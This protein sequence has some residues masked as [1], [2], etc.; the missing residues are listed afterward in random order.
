[1]DMWQS[2]PNPGTFNA[3]PGASNPP[4]PPLTQALIPALTLA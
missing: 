1:M 2:N 3:L 4:A